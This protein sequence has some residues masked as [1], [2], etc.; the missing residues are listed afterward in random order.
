MIKVDKEAFRATIL[1]MD[2]T[3]VAAHD[4][5]KM[6]VAAGGAAYLRN[7]RQNMSLRDHSLQDLARQG[8]PYAHRHG[9]IGI[10]GGSAK[11]L[12]NPSFRVHQQT[13]T[14]LNAT[15]GG[16]TPA[17]QATY[18]IAV[19]TGLAPHGAY[20]IQGTKVML[21]RDVI[22]DTGMARATQKS[23]RKA[24]IM[25]LG[26]ILRSKARLRIGSVSAE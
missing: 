4:A 14:L 10:H 19:D 18:R 7:V 25:T 20:V 26:P 5:A 17:R 2:E 23:I 3:R 21:P 9:S 6:A 8:H 22:W 13:G 15:K 11:T 1:A 16:L 24:I 12:V